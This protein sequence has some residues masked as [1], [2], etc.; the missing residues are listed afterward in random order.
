MKLLLT[1]LS[2]TYVL[3]VPCYLYAFAQLYRI[4]DAERPEWVRRSGSLSFFYDGLPR[5]ADPNVT[6][7]I[8]R[9]AF[10][11]RVH[12]L[13]APKAAFY[14]RLIRILLLIG[15]TLFAFILYVI[16]PFKL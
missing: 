5:P 3:I 6:V 16:F 14:A 12:E 9:T 8:I 1:L 13:R 10:S 4:V 11:S 15:L 2:W 7:A